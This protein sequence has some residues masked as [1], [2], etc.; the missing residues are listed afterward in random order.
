MIFIIL[1]SR[2]IRLF[3]CLEEIFKLPHI[4]K[5]LNRNELLNF[6]ITFQLLNA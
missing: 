4:K 2:F 3:F 6:A 5:S 1:K